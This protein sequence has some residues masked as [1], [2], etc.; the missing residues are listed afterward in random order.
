MPGHRARVQPLRAAPAAAG[1][2]SG[3]LGAGARRRED[4]GATRTFGTFSNSSSSSIGGGSSSAGSG[5]SAVSAKPLRPS[6]LRASG[7]TT[8]LSSRA[9]P[10]ASTGRSSGA[11]ARAGAGAAAG[12]GGSRRSGSAGSGAAGGGSEDLLKLPWV[13][14]SSTKSSGS[15]QQ[16]ASRDAPAAGGANGGSGGGKRG[17]ETTN[18]GGAIGAEAS[19]NEKKK[20]GEGALGRAAGPPR[21]A[22][23][24]GYTNGSVVVPAESSVFSQMP[25]RFPTR[26]DGSRTDESAKMLA[27]AQVGVRGAFCFV[28]FFVHGGATIDALT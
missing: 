9:H 11:G 6:A 15:E 25:Q 17:E 18:A 7:R 27:D 13:Y 28:L 19:A 20:A 4:A 23:P 2:L 3:I 8:V 1:T 14:G 21:E 12:A 22:H 26:A 10:P 16:S 5:A 24:A